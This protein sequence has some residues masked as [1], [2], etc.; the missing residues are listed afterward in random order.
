[1][2]QIPYIAFEAEMARMERI[3]RRLWALLLIAVLLLVASNVAWIE[4]ERQFE[5]VTETTYEAESEAGGNAVI[6]CSGEVT[7]N[8]ASES[9]EK[10]IP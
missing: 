4:Y 8:G 3:I 7:I 9:N 1:M 6:N 10:V 2:E 5:G